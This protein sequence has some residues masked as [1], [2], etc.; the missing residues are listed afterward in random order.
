MEMTGE[1]RDMCFQVV[2]V[3]QARRVGPGSCFFEHR[4]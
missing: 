1:T 2:I 3:G 4:Q